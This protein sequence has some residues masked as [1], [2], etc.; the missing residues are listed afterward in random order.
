MLAYIA[1]ANQVDEIASMGKT[2]ILE[3]MMRFSSAIEALYTNEYLQKPTPR[4]MR[5]LLRKDEM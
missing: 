1:S 3:S 5:R 4:D 2:T